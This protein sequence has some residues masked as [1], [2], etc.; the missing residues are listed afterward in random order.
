[1]PS[2][3]D[4]NPEA[5][6]LLPKLPDCGCWVRGGHPRWELSLRLGRSC[7]GPAYRWALCE[8]ASGAK[9]EMAEQFPGE[10]GRIPWP[11]FQDTRQTWAPRPLPGLGS[12]EMQGSTAPPPANPDRTGVSLG[13]FAF[14]PPQAQENIPLV[15]LFSSICALFPFRYPHL[16]PQRSCGSPPSRSPPPLLLHQMPT[17]P[18]APSQFTVG[19]ADVTLLPGA[20]NLG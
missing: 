10:G 15:P 16:P 1:M 6:T 3:S 5:E 7:R 9:E 11:G 12:G 19:T 17:C 8:E 4:R 20:H 18:L 13:F 14:P 2:A